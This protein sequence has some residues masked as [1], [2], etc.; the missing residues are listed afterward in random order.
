MTPAH[1]GSWNIER[2][3]FNAD[4]KSEI[5]CTGSACLQQSGVTMVYDEAV[6][7]RLGDKPIHATRRYRFVSDAQTIV[8]S[9][10]EGAPFFSLRLDPAGTGHAVHYCGDDIYT[11]NLTL[12]SDRW[13]TDW[14]IRGTKYLRI[15]TCYYR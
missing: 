11:L 6:W 1:A 15:V 8:A 3:I 13:H 7:F 2:T 14:V 9:F 4:D 10:G 12:G 5:R